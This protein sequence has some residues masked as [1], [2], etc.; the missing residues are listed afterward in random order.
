MTPIEAVF[1]IVV[2]VLLCAILY[3]LKIPQFT[4]PTNV[5]PP[6]YEPVPD[7]EVLDNPIVEFVELESMTKAELLDLAELREVSVA[8]SWTKGKIVEALANDQH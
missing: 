7:S 5:E 6:R 4:M 2:V 8:K 1:M 3:S